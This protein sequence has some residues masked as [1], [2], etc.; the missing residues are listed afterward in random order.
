MHTN[1]FHSSSENN[2]TQKTYHEALTYL[3]RA[4]V[5]QTQ[6]AVNDALSSLAENI[7][8]HNANNFPLF[9]SIQG[10]QLFLANHL[11]SKISTPLQHDFIQIIAHESQGTM[12]WRV[13]PQIDIQQR[14]VILLD[15]L[16]NDGQTLLIIQEKLKPYVN[17]IKTLVLCDKKN[18]NKLMKPDYHC[19]ETPENSYIFGCGMSINQHWAHLPNLYILQDS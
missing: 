3:K 2:P 6:S 12:D 11:L 13:L 4:T 15:D 17:S 16:L 5:W 9:L 7:M 8:Q 19:F 10:S 14:D 18:H 1:S